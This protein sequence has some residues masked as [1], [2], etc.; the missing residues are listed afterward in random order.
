MTTGVVVGGAGLY[1]RGQ[2][3]EVGDLRDLRYRRHPQEHVSAGQS[4]PTRLP[5]S[6]LLD[7]R[8]LRVSQM[9]LWIGVHQAPSHL[10]FPHPLVSL[11]PGLFLVQAV[12]RLRS[13]AGNCVIQKIVAVFTL[14]KLDYSRTVRRSTWAL[15]F[16][17]GEPSR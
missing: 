15:S 4:I 1:L 7:R 9:R 16:Q 14:G 3:G 10:R 8:T 11:F 12:D 13:F 5:T 2:G 6:Q 17:N